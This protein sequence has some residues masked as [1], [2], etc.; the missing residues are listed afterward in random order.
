MLDGAWPGDEAG[1]VHQG[2]REEAEVDERGLRRKDSAGRCGEEYARSLGA[3]VLDG[4][5]FWASLAPYRQSDHWH[6]RAD[7]N[8]E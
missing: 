1:V 3:L 2:G 4:T 7:L 8:T 5:A 6:Y